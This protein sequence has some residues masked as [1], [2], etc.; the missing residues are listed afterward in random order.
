MKPDILKDPR[1]THLVVEGE[2]LGVPLL[3]ADEFAER[4]DLDLVDVVALVVVAD[5]EVA[6][7][8]DAQDHSAKNGAEVDGDMALITC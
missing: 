5:L 8:E 6:R 3:E 1:R 4:G 7:D 2:E